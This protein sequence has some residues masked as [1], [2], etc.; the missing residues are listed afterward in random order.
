[1]RIRRKTRKTFAVVL[2]VM[3]LSALVTAMTAANTV[4]TAKAGEGSGAISGYTVSAVDYNVNATNPANI[5]SVS[6]TLDSAPAGGATV[7]IKLVSAGSTWYSCTMS[8]TPAVNASC[9]TSGATVA[10]ADLLSVVV[11]D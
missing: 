4:P 6:F 3:G 7:K 10:L 5:D 9:T 8:G 1:M 2:V 11:A